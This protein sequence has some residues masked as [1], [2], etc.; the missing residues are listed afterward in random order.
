M[1][2]MMTQPA[3]RDG[4]NKVMQAMQ[5]EKWVLLW[6][7]LGVS[8]LN[9]AINYQQLTMAKSFVLGAVLSYLSQLVFAM[10]VFKYHSGRAG[11]QIVNHLYLG[12]MVKWLIS[13]SGFAAVFIFIKPL[14]PLAVF[15]GY[16]LMQAVHVYVMW[17]IS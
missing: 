11:R 6:L 15:A 9:V 2:E 5:R 12:V 16:L 3:K 8:L 10:I 17:R 14:S 1:S 7:V 4:K 13:L